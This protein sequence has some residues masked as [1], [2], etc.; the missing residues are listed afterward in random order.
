MVG[1]LVRGALDVVGCQTVS[2]HPLLDGK[3]RLH[4]STVDS[5]RGR[6]GDATSDILR[7]LDVA[8][9]G[10]ARVMLV[11]ARAVRQLLRGALLRVR[12]DGAGRA[13]VG[14]RGGLGDLGA[15]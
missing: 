7:L 11:R 6:L 2:N 12:H 15:C 3:Q 9:A 14:P 4:T 1:V 10:V 5:V 13:V 8:L